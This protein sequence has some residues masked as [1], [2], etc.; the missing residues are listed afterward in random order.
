MELLIG[1]TD[2]K[3]DEPDVDLPTVHTYDEVFKITS[4]KIRDI[5]TTNNT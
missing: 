2:R 5:M 3:V 1:C 4:A